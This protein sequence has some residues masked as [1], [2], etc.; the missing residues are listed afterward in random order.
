MFKSLAALGLAA[1]AAGCSTTTTIQAL[2]PAPV[3]RAASLKQ[4]AIVDFDNDSGRYGVNFAA[5]LEALMTNYQIAGKN[6]FTVVSR[7]DLDRILDEQKRQNSG[8]FSANKMAEFGKLTGAQAMIS[9]SVSSASSNDSHYRENRSRN[10]CD[11]NGK[12]CQTIEY[13]V[14]CTLRVVSLGVQVRMVDVERG[15]LVTAESLEEA[16]EWSACSDRKEVLPS[17]AQGL[18]KLSN[19]LAQQ[20]VAK[21]T[22]RYVSFEVTL[23]EDPD[24]VLSGNQD[25]RFEAAIEFVEIGRIDRADD[26]L[27]QLHQEVQQQSYAIAYN[28]G[29]IKESRADYDQAKALY[30]IADRLALEP[31]DAINAAVE[32]IGRIQADNK[33]A[34]SQLNRS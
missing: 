30:Q 1:L 28:L 22:P 14:G 17:R 3:D 27:S 26:L 10:K 13:T 12:N 6:Y 11:S 2:K 33:K 25:D 21:I 5:K 19:A 18:E 24:V 15:D 23:L 4:V 31:V 20:F 16:Y 34:L 32:R 29:V 7:N 8:L 9:G